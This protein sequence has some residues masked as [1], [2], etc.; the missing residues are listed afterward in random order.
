MSTTVSPCEGSY[1]PFPLVSIHSKLLLVDKESV[2]TT[3]F[4]SSPV[5]VNGEEN[6]PV[7][8]HEFKGIGDVADKGFGTVVAPAGAWPDE[9]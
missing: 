4:F 7:T 6:F 8:T 9:E 5:I 3:F 2:I 1:F